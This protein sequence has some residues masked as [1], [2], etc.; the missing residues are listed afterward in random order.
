MGCKWW[1]NCTAELWGATH[2]AFCCPSIL[3]LIILTHLVWIKF[4]V[5]RTKQIWA[6][7]QVFLIQFEASQFILLPGSWLSTNLPWL[8]WKEG[9][10]LTVIWFPMSS[11]WVGWGKGGLGHNPSM[12]CEIMEGP[13]SRKHLF[14]PHSC[15]HPGGFASPYIQLTQPLDRIRWPG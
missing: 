15:I 3:P 6:K 2:R 13:S 1:W 4:S 5:C 8:A 9:K 10:I 12:G 11:F 14:S 7:S